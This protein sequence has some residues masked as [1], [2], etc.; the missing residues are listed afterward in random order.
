MCPLSSRL[1]TGIYAAHLV[2]ADLIDCVSG[3]YPLGVLVIFFAAE[4]L[5]D[6]EVE[7]L[8]MVSDGQRAAQGLQGEVADGDSDWG[9]R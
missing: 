9:H 7:R 6:I 3:I 4:I 2:V 5:A 1:R 8:E